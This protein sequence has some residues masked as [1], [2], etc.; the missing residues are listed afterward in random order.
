MQPRSCRNRLER[1]DFA[2]SVEPMNSVPHRRLTTIGWMK[3]RM[4][5]TMMSQ[6][7]FVR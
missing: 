7:L 1:M 6:I 5:R 2:C 4:E 3:E